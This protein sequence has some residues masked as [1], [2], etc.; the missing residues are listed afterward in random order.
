MKEH[1]IITYLL[2]L[3]VAYYFAFPLASFTIIVTVSV[4]LPREKFWVRS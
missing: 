3:I 2:P 4:I 1:A